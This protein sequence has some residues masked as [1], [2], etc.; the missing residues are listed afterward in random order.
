M[1]VGGRTEAG[2][3]PASFSPRAFLRVNT[4]HSGG[5]PWR[6]RTL[7]PMSQGRCWP[8]VLQLGPLEDSA[9]TQRVLVVVVDEAWRL[10]LTRGSL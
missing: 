8:G 9:R 7:S 4:S 3:D 2:L 10:E 5:Q 1:V 6:R